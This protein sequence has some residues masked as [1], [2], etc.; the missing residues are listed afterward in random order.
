MSFYFF[1]SANLINRYKNKHFFFLLADETSRYQKKIWHKRQH[2]DEILNSTPAPKKISTVPSYLL[3]SSTLSLD[4]HYTWSSPLSLSISIGDYSS[5]HSD[6][7]PAPRLQQP[8]HAVHYDGSAVT[9]TPCPGDRFDD[10]EALWWAVLKRSPPTPFTAEVFFQASCPRCS[11]S[12]L[13]LEHIALGYFPVSELTTVPTTG[14]WA[15]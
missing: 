8:P 5:S 1:V 4:L 15:W 10:K 11:C 9:T 2:P 6:D 13:F 3:R 7:H 14:T 12:R